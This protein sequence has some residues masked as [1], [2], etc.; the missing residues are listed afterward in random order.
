M[1]RTKQEITDTL[2]EVYR[3]VCA[4]DRQGVDKPAPKLIAQV[5]RMLEP[6]R[7]TLL[8]QRARIELRSAPKPAKAAAAQ[9]EAPP[10]VGKPQ[11]AQPSRQPQPLKVAPGHPPLSATPKSGAE[12]GAENV[13]AAEPLTADEV[14]TM[15]S[16]KPADA[17]ER[18]SAERVRATLVS[19]GT[20]A[21]GLEIKT[22][23]QLFNITRNA[24][25]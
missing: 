18:Y 17:E 8:V 22:Y 24:F 15:L 21:D 11:G 16:M 9:Q 12:A 25:A 1:G 3:D 2:L 6:Q 20:D 10:V 19:I 5:V 13:A 23:R 7:G 14:E 4:L